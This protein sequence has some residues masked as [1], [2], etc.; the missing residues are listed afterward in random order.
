MAVISFMIKAQLETVNGEK[1]LLNVVTI[2]IIFYQKKM[3]LQLDFNL[4]GDSFSRSLSSRRIASQSSSGQSTISL[5]VAAMK[6]KRTVTKTRQACG[7]GS[8]FQFV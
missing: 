4:F 2:R 8:G 5:P 3:K 1:G 6:T 7:K